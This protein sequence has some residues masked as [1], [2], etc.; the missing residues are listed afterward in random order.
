[1]H[2]GAAPSAPP[3]CHRQVVHALL[4]ALED[5]DSCGQQGIS[6][7]RWRAL[8]PDAAGQV[9]WC[10]AI[11]HPVTTCAMLWHDSGC[12]EGCCETQC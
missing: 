7:G 5:G 2:A 3:V 4:E 8:M 10:I 11:A 6:L 1:M 12:R 9:T